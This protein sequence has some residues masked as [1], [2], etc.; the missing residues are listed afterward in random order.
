ME[1]VES[2]VVLALRKDLEAMT[3]EVEALRQRAAEA[4]SHDA[5]S[6]RLQQALQAQ[7][8]EDSLKMLRLLQQQEKVWEAVVAERLSEQAK[9]LGARFAED[10]EKLR[11]DLGDEH[12]NALNAALDAA[13][14]DFAAR[15]EV[16]R[17]SERLAHETTRHA[18]SSARLEQL[19]A[20]HEAVE[21]FDKAY[22]FDAEYKR[23]SHGV[24]SLTVALFSLDELLAGRSAGT[25][26]EHLSA[27]RN[28]AP[29]DPVVKAAIASLPPD[30]L[31]ADQAPATVRQLQRRFE[32]VASKTR[33]AAYVPAGTGIFG[34][35]VGALISTLAFAEEGL[36]QG[37]DAQAVIARAQHYVNEDRL[38]DVRG[39]AAPLM[40]RSRAHL[41]RRGVRAPRRPA[42]AL[43]ELSAL[44]GLPRTVAQ[45]WM[46]AAHKRCTLDQART[47]LRAH[48]TTLAC[49]LA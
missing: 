18:E 37:E 14:V 46:D 20:L 22:S 6:R 12:E 21:A 8:E 38:Q 28:A 2:S 30:M 7:E 36:V 48:V 29:T 33:V 34:Q 17:Q 4:A 3:A 15:M 27:V 41:S 42:Q 1:A 47:L 45:D 26:A 35:V 9:A 16:L 5:D 49:A 39:A 25:L 19:A 44:R 11:S 23:R 24:H 13:Q 32:T 10:A 31:E 43:V 40:G